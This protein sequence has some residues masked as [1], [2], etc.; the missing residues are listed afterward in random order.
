M[1]DQPRF[2]LLLAKAPLIYSK[3]PRVAQIKTNSGQLQFILKRSLDEIQLTSDQTCLL[4]QGA[5]G[6]PLISLYPR[7]T[8]WL[9]DINQRVIKW[10]TR[11]K[12]G[13]HGPMQN[14]HLYYRPPLILLFPLRSAARIWVMAH[15][16]AVVSPTDNIWVLWSLYNRIQKQSIFIYQH[17]LY[18]HIIKLSCNN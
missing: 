13:L 11:R 4:V 2:K 7:C 14:S 10:T 9:S 18:Q 12:A 1:H 5:E 16:S 3:W 6:F 8:S 15:I 17:I